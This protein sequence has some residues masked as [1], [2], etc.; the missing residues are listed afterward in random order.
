MPSK[1]AIFFIDENQRVTVSDAGS[2]ESIRYF[3]KELNADVY[4]MKLDSQFRC[5]GADGYLAWLDDV[6][7]IKETANFDGFEF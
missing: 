6:L 1:F 3:A 2:K 7:E 5:N 4:E